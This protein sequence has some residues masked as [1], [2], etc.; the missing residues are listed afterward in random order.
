MYISI[1][2][3]IYMVWYGNH[4]PAWER[5]GLNATSS[6]GESTSRI[7]LRAPRGRA[8]N[9]GVIQKQGSINMVVLNS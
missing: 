2:I 8:P 5:R 4:P 9:N 7:R 1:Y 3:Y 6:Q